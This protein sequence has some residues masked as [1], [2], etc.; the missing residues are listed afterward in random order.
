VFYERYE[1]RE[2]VA[3][4]DAICFIDGD[5]WVGEVK[6][7]ASEF[8]PKEM[9]KL[10]REA[11]KMHA[12]KA[13]AFALEGDQDALQRVCDLISNSSEVPVIHLRPHSWGKN[14][15]FHI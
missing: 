15:S 14:P 7:N 10:I 9:D 11:R 5:L 8:K 3:E 4:L 2:P 13:F 6:T 12:D 1:D